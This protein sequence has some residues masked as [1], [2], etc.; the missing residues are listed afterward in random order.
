VTSFR[1]AAVGGTL[2]TVALT[3]LTAGLAVAHAVELA[4]A[5]SASTFCPLLILGIWW[6]GLTAIGAT[7]GLLLGGV[8][9]SIPVVGAMAGWSPGGALGAILTQPAMVTV[10]IAFATMVGVSLLT[11]A[12][13]PVH[14]GRTMIR[15]HT[16]E[17]VAVDR[18]G[19][20]TRVAE[21]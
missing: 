6:R 12:H 16:P 13:R 2:L 9:S 1:V 4:F 5:V 14:V 18:S 17:S 15:L 21:D 3:Q 19:F 8:T 11:S 10:P 7:A 20:R